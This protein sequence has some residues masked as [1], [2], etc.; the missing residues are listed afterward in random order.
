MRSWRS[1]V[2]PRNDGMKIRWIALGATIAGLFSVLVSLIAAP[3]Y[4]GLVIVALVLALL[5]LSGSLAVIAKSSSKLKWSI[6]LAVIPVSVLAVD[7][8]GRLLMIMN[9]GGFRILI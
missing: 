4:K 6:L 2:N 9:L 8:F 1:T 5:S 7:N 3:D